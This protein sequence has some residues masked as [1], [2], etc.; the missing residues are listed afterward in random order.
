MADSQRSSPVTVSEAARFLGVSVHTVRG[1]VDRGDLRG[2]ALPSG[3]RR[4]EPR[5]LEEL[6]RGAGRPAA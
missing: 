5:S 4:I 3:H 1:L 2:F 6:R